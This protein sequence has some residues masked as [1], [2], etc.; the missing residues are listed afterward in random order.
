MNFKSLIKPHHLHVDA[1][2]LTDTFGRFV[3]EPLERGYGVTIGNSLRR[4][5]LSSIP[6]AA[7]ASIRI[8]GRMLY[9]GDAEKL[10]ATWREKRNMPNEVASEIHT[11]VMGA[12]IPEAVL[13]ARDL[14]LPPPVP[15]PQ[16]RF[17]QKGPD[18]KASFRPEVA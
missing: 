13:V 4:L 2:T 17:E 12:C 10:A 3:A 15:L 1:A 6:G 9:Q 16:V 8:E 14:H 11:A 5:L 18:S 7:V